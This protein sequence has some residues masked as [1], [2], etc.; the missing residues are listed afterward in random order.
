MKIRRVVSSVLVGSLSVMTLSGCWLGAG[1]AAGEG[2][3][4]ATRKDRSAGETLDDQLILASVKAQLIGDPE[5][6]GFSINVDVE[7]GAVTLR[8]YVPSQREIDRAVQL[9]RETKGVSSVESKL[10]L[11]RKR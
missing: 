10:V 4:L 7:K 1:A 8:G 9:A 11:D 2:A 5:V 3:Y 6:S